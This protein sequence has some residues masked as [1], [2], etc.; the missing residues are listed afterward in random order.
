MAS[1][2]DDPNFGSK[3]ISDPYEQTR[4]TI[5]SGAERREQRERAR[6]DSQIKREL[7]RGRLSE[8]TKSQIAEQALEDFARSIIQQKT[9][10]IQNS[11]NKESPQ[12]DISVDTTTSQQVIPI[13]SNVAPSVPQD[14]P[15]EI[16]EVCK[17]GRK[18]EM[19]IYGGIERFLE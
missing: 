15:S 17:D 9:Q 3:K 2:L 10:Q 7:K 5:G 1:Q 13:P 14:L 11:F 8:R 6:L 4:E 12:P 19:R 18:A 16:V